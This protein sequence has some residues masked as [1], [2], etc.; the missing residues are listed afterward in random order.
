MKLKKR[1]EVIREYKKY[2]KLEVSDS[3]PES[4]LF[5]KLVVSGFRPEKQYPI[6]Y[7]FTDLAFPKEKIAIEYDGKI[8]QGNEDEDVKRQEEIKKLG[9]KV[10]RIKNVG[11][12]KG[13]YVV[14]NCWRKEVGMYADMEKAMDS[15]VSE[16]A[17]HLKKDNIF[18]NEKREFKNISQYLIKKINDLG[19]LIE[20]NN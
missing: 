16:V 11:L 15:L 17:W 7:Y 8:H 13:Y 10:F 9:W 12:R 6:G 2:Y 14:I 18:R 5:E 1:K 19:D 4:V 20:Q 3:D